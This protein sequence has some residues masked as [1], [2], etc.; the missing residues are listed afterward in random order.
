MVKSSGFKEVSRDF[1][2]LVSSKIRILEKKNLIVLKAK[3]LTL[4]NSN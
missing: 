4:T 2:L 3:G 1:Y